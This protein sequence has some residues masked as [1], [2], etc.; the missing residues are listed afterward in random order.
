[1]SS[2]EKGSKQ[3]FKRDLKTFA[4]LETTVRNKSNAFK[5]KNDIPDFL[6]NEQK[7]NVSCRAHPKNN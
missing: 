6:R 2:Q 5:F 4:P 7:I 1:M 3:L